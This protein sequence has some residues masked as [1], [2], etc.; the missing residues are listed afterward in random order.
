MAEGLG[1]RIIKLEISAPGI[2]LRVLP[3]QFVVLMVSEKGERI[4][5]TVVDK[6]REKG[7][8][9]LIFQELGLTTHLLGRLGK[10]ER[11]YALLGPLG[12]PSEIKNYGKVVLVGGGVGI[13]EIFPVAK[14]LKEKGNYLTLLL[15]ARTKNLLILEEELRR[16]A[17][18][19]Y[20]AT[21]D[22]S[23]GW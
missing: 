19:I 3:G 2:S 15:G 5:L 18:E 6:D 23:Y 16:I 10:G 7:T 8:L 9:V 1:T 17:D 22:G 11:L 21:D 13:A 4:P 12:N 14:A 20:T